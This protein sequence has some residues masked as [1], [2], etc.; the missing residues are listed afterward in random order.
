M[1]EYSAFAFLIIFGELSMPIISALGKKSLVLFPG[2]HPISTTVFG[3]L[4]IRIAKSFAG[5][6]RSF[7][8]F[9]YCI[10]FQSDIY[11]NLS[12]FQI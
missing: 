5:C 2:P 9:K 12:N 8:N 6:V 4:L 7:L 10:E 11:F 1:S 3:L